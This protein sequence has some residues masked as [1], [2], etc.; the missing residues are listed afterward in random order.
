MGNIMRIRQLGRMKNESTFPLAPGGLGT[1]VTLEVFPSYRHR[2]HS[3]HD[4]A[5]DNMSLD[6][7]WAYCTFLNHRL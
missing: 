6:K 2:T 1:Y 5:T 4:G 3:C 7:L